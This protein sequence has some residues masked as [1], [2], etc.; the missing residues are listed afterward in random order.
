MNYFYRTIGVV[1][2]GI[3]FLTVFL[4]PA[5]AQQ[6]NEDKVNI[7]IR[8][9]KLEEIIQA[10]MKQTSVKIV[11]NQE[12]VQK[13]P[14]QTF[15]AK[16][17]PLK[18]VMKR[19]LKG[20]AL[21]FVM[22][23]KVMVIAPKEEEDEEAK[24]SNTM[25]GM[26][27]D[28]KGNPIPAVTVN[29][30]GTPST[31]FTNEKGTFSILLE[32]GRS[33][34]FSS[35]GF[36]KKTVK[37]KSGEM[38]TVRLE[39]E[40]NEMEEF[41]VT[42]YQTVNKRLSAS[43]TYTLKGTEV[44]EPGATN[45][46]SML[47]GKVP[48]LSIAKNSGS[49]NAIPSMRMRGTSTLIGNANPIIV[50]DGIIRENPNAINPDN[51][52]GV[53]PT[54]R[55]MYLMKDGILSKASLTG[56]SIS[57]LNVN[58]V[59]SITFLKDASATAIY[60]TRAA[61]GVIV[62]TTKKGK[63]GKPEISY[64]STLGTSRRPQYSD[65]Q[66]MNSQQ[67]V[68]FS[69]EMYQDGYTY[70]SVPINM[71]YEGAFMDLMNK[72]IT[73]GQFQKAVADLEKMN[74]DWFGILFQNTLNVSQH[75]S[76]SGGSEKTSYY[77]SASYDDNQGTAKKDRLREGGVSVAINS[78]LNR[79][80]TLNF[81]LNGSQRFSSGYFSVNPLDY[82]IQTSRA[83]SPSLVYPSIKEDSFGFIT[84]LDYNILNEIEQTGSSVKNSQLASSL[85]L[86][87]L[88]LRGLTFTS[89]ASGNVNA[90]NSEQY[91]TELSNY[92]ALSR[93]Y[94]YGSVTPGSAMELNSILPFGG[95][96]LPSSS[97]VYSYTLRNMAEFNRSIFTEN[98]VFNI[99][100]GQ[101]IRSVKNDGLDNLLPGYLRDRGEGFSMVPNSI[102]MI[103][104]KR[105]NTLNNFM[106]LFATA[107]YSYANKYIINGNI[108]TDASNRFG[109]FAN[110]RFLPV[111]S[112][113]GRWNISA[114]KWLQNSKII[115]DLGLK[116][117]YG[118]QG[119]VISS[120]GPDLILTIPDVNSALNGGANEFYLNIKSLPY[121]GLR[122]EKT[123][124]F[125][126]EVNGSLFNS[127]LNFGMAYYH[128]RTTDAI[129]S[130]FIPLEYGVATML[131]NGGNI[132][133][134][135]YEM[136]LGMNLIR[137]ENLKWRMSVNSAKNFNTL[138]K[139]TIETTSTIVTDYLNGTVLVEGQPINTFYVFSFKGLNPKTGV[140]LFYGIDEDG[141][142]PKGSFVDYLKPAGSRMA[143]ISG[144][145][146]TSVD[147]HA[148]S[149]GMSFAFKLGSKRLR[150]PVYKVS[151]V[152][153]PMT[154]E[155]LPAILE[156][157]W[158][159]PGDEAFT[160]IP[161]YPK[162]NGLQGEGFVVMTNQTG[163]T[164]SSMSRY[165]MYN[166][167]DANLVSGSFLRCNAI[168]FSYRLADNL[169]KRMKVKQI[170][171]SGTASNLF[172]IA[173]KKLRGQD[174]E[175]DGVGTTALPISK[176]FS[177]GLNV[178]F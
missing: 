98:D 169:V 84:P 55:D 175:I 62:I 142:V 166:H 106:S 54:S 93:G 57:G 1:I 81:N 47:Q 31:T 117:S 8:N 10:V 79:K 65:M 15:I 18:S 88:I 64:S 107:S 136:Q 33:L 115:N 37:P 151:D 49:P 28:D 87:Y 29:V 173:D 7:D 161:A 113:A 9:G 124:S 139:G 104:P 103:S 19:L 3:M 168:N 140:P 80:L 110:Q 91:A 40:L 14:R 152:S 34:T 42:G 53:E 45:I 75:L 86:N 105:T 129:T 122:W 6:K 74:T 63:A 58:D 148:F 44:K 25:K 102:P 41:V 67:R 163:S 158:R 30:T 112:I 135:G 68:R 94:N 131:V 61:N 17:E 170:S 23:D 174:P 96:L 164:T 21:T 133:N 35:V 36:Q 99:V 172:V 76:L 126:L 154:Q 66:L 32:E 171:V 77:S 125:N 83:I 146:N 59:E 111:W 128:K 177:L 153:I 132:K 138:E 162:N 165:D 176:I 95:V 97:S 89:L 20:S 127:F 143:K 69:R 145:L 16:N 26:V 56:N 178:T 149:L 39:S 46:V 156:Q 13:S 48:G 2:Y 121:P 11:Y 92:V 109:Q 155:N 116:A 108:R 90:L 43:S 71:G 114:E 82:A 73:E 60:G 5:L 120:V 167:S 157:R 160:D 101:E 159:K 144:G 137:K 38:I 24:I 27:Q 51:L 85:S 70:Q 130:K 147:Y 134:Y 123:K 52:L 72:K 78:Q 150:N 22:M 119:N 50:V 141:V 100:A 4:Q 118:F 12:L